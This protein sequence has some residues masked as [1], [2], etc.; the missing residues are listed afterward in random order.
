MSYARELLGTDGAHRVLLFLREE[1]QL[2]AVQRRV[3]EL[4]DRQ[5]LPLTPLT[6]SSWQEVQKFYDQLKS[7][8]DVLFTF[9]VV[10]VT[11]LSMVAIFAIL[12]VSFLERLRELGSLRAIGTTRVSYCCCWWWRPWG[13]T[14]LAP[15]WR[16]GWARGQ[17]LQRAAERSTKTGSI[18]SG[19]LP[20][21]FTHLLTRPR[22]ALV[23]VLRTA[24]MSV[25]NVLRY[26]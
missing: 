6:V 15:R 5:E 7:F 8:Y 17:G 14:C 24:R 1:G 22:A 16:L 2:A 26:E 4:I 12:S 3:V 9:M 10:V 18:G 13:C 25:A 19:T 23:P 20:D 21:E 11:L